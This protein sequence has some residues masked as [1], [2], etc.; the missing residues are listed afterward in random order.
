MAVFE[1]H[2]VKMFFG[3]AGGLLD[4]I[5]KDGLLAPAAGVVVSLCCEIEGQSDHEVLACF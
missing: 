1:W 3:P 5:I 2:Y 4:S